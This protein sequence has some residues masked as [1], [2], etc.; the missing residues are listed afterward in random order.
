[1]SAICLESEL[2]AHHVLV[3]ERKSVALLRWETVFRAWEQGH[4]QDARWNR[5]SN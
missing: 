1:M 2:S 5:N 4:V 3:K